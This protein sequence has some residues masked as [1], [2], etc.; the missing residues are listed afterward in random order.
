MTSSAAGGA[1]PTGTVALLF[2]DIAGSTVRWER[3]REAMRDA[4]TLHDAILRAAIEAHGGYVFKTVGDAFCATFRTV[5]EAVVAALQAQRALRDTD[6]SAVEGIAVR[7]A[8][9][10]G[11][12]DERDGDYFGPAVNRV[13]RILATA[14]GGQTILSAAAGAL[15]RDALPP[16]AELID[17]GEHR[18]KDLATAEC[19][20]QLTVPDL[21]SAFPPLRSL[22]ARRH[23]LPVQLTPLL[24]RDELVAEVAASLAVRRLVSLA[25]PGGV[26][27]TRVALAAA[28]EVLARG[29]GEVAFVELA[30]IDAGVLASAVALA[31]GVPE[32][33]GDPLES[34]A[35]GIGTRPV[36]LVLDN[37]EHVVREAARAA[38]LLLERCPAVRVL[39]TTREPLRV[40]GECV[41]RVPPLGLPPA[42][43]PLRAGEALEHG[44]IALFV[45]RARAVEPSFRLTDDGAPLVADIC[46]RLDGIA[47]AIEL[48]AARTRV[49]PLR[50]LA[51]KLDERFR[52]LTGG[53]RTRLPRQQT[54]LALVDWS[55]E[56]LDDAEKREFRRLSVFAG[57]WS[58]EDAVVLCADESLDEYGVFDAVAALAE[59]SLVAVEGDDE[60]RYALLET[61]RAF[62]RLRL[63]EAGETHAMRARHAAWTLQTARRLE[64]QWEHLPTE[65]WEGAMTAFFQN[66]RLALGF[67]LREG[68][69]VALGI[70][71]AGALRIFLVSYV[72]AEGAAIVDE[73]LAA[74]Q[75]SGAPP[76][77]FAPLWHAVAMFAHR[78]RDFER[79]L[80]AAERARAAYAS[81][82]NAVGAALARKERADACESLGRSDEAA[83]IYLEVLATLRELGATRL[84]ALVL[85]DVGI[86]HYAAGRID[87]TR[88]AYAE[89]IDK[90]TA[91]GY[92]RALFFGELNLAEVEYASG[93]VERAVALGRSAGSRMRRFRPP[94]LSAL[95]KTNLAFYLASAGLPGEAAAVARDGLAVSAGGEYVPAYLAIQTL[96]EAAADAGDA[97]AA[98]TLL[99]FVDTALDRV[100]AVRE[101]TEAD[102]YVRLL[103]K[104]GDRLDPQ[105]RTR[106]AAAGA[107]LTLAA[108]TA[109]ALAVGAPEAPAASAPPRS[110]A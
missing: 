29:S 86:A 11:T 62:A 88:A 72:P 69:D 65:V 15:A 22:D 57:D 68:N 17:L 39:A 45:E 66:A 90:A 7:M 4:V 18:L 8:I 32:A 50:A 76:K 79:Q 75:A 26:G 92:D 82:G 12:T 73:A 53:G 110:P 42:G 30:A 99:G 94:F 98:A 48:A 71:L 58:L 100:R 54:L 77:A 97:D 9:H 80:E 2:T 36:L 55:Y 3:A 81:A 34:L 67:A 83:A 23:N 95:A 41:V 28:A 107:E 103:Q 91:S 56:L 74:A 87:D 44:A 24:G 19:L 109:L 6:W 104:L 46:R 105:R 78:S 16:G 85:V 89:A 33:A 10:C 31:L 5:A 37:C 13:A 102:A 27:K 52:L 35:H 38:A 40:A 93:D 63:D 49:L 51:Q 70:A 108:A 21:P 14:H 43:A 64:T 61:M 25:G 60:K 106:L 84:I 59:K 96:A 20:A 1:R 47:L 101:R